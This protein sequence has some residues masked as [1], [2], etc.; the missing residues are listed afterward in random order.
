LTKSNASLP[1][2]AGAVSLGS[3]EPPEEQACRNRNA[4]SIITRLMRMLAVRINE[5]W[6]I[7]TNGLT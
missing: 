5:E 7:T 6:L 2:R 3:E 1:A 4:L